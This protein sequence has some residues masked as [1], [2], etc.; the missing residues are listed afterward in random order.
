ML[1][2]WREKRT[3]HAQTF[4]LYVVAGKYPSSQLSVDPKRV[5]LNAA[6]QLRVEK[7]RTLIAAIFDKPLSDTPLWVK[8]FKKPLGSIITSPYGVRRVFNGSLKSYHSGV[9][10]RAATGTSIRAANAGI[11]RFAGNLFYAGN[12]VV[13]G[14][15][16]GIFTAYAHLSRIDVQVNQKVERGQILGRSGATGRVSGPHLH[17][18]FRV[19]GARPDPMQIYPLL[20]QIK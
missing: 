2:R 14:H 16:A 3:P 6:D 18:S 4:D 13:L 11:V 20:N 12:I 19:A 1:V 17:W 10:F 15:G 5:R 9:D 7:E 8:D